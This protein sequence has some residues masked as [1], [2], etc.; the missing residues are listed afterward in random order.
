MQIFVKTAAAPRQSTPT[1][2]LSGGMQ[3]FV[4]TTV[5]L[6]LGHLL[7]FSIFV[8]AC[9]SS[10]PQWNAD[11]RQDGSTSSTLDTKSLSL[12]LH[13]DLRQD[14]LLSLLAV[15]L[16]FSIFLMACRSSFPQRNADF[17]GVSG[18]FS[19]IDTNPL[20]QQIFV[21]TAVPLLLCPLPSTLALQ[22]CVMACRSSNPRWNAHFCHDG[23][24]FSTIDTNSPSQRWHAD[25]RQDLIHDH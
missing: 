4:K 3:I 20:S 7:Q 8:M 13:A 5:P 14:S 21:K 11:F 23:G 15:R 19:I 25:L 9:R 16:Q 12:R 18:C 10:F 1:L 2:H 17:R 24:C 6:F 22:F